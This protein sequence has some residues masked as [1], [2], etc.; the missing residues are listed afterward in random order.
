MRIIS[1]AKAACIVATGAL[2]LGGCALP[3]RKAP[4]N[5]VAFDRPEPGS[6]PAAVSRWKEEKGRQRGTYTR[7]EGD[8]TYVLVAW[9]EKRT[10][11]YA[12]R[13]EEIARGRDG[14]VV[15]V[16]LVAPGADQVVT[17]ALTYPS[18]LVVTRER[19]HR[20]VLFTYTGNLTLTSR[21]Q[22]AGPPAQGEQGPATSKNFVINFPA[23]GSLITSPVRIAGR[24]RV[25]EATFFIEIEDGHNVLARQMV[26]ASA[27]GPEW[28]TFDITVPFEE[29]TSPA[30]AII[31]VTY[32]AKDGS[33]QEELIL[34]VLFAPAGS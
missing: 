9:G 20:P 17:Q 2:V 16:R 21:L 33:R 8:R 29:P 28:G 1:I 22:E 13:I 26:A 7:D 23:S 10:G 6:L 31:F 24:A 3:G 34:P 5:G 25:F 32:G 19:L 15:V 14:D 4:P 11:G 12:V 30:G 27:G 18:D